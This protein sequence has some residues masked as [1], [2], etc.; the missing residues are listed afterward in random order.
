METDSSVA[1][2]ASAVERVLAEH[3]GGRWTVASVAQSWTRRSFE[4]SDGER[5][6]FVKLDVRAD[7]LRRLAE[8]GVAPPVLHDGEHGGL[9]L[10]VQEFIDGPPVERDWFPANLPTLAK[11]VT[12][13]HDD[14][15]LTTM[16]VPAAGV[17]YR[18]VVERTVEDL[19]RRSAATAC[20]A[21]S[22][23]VF[24][25]AAARVGAAASSLAEVP[26]VPTHGDPNRRNVVI[27]GERP[28]FVDGDEIAMADPLRDVG[29]L[30][31]WYLPRE[32]W[33]EFLHLLGIEESAATLDRLFWWVATEF[34]E[35]SLTTAAAGLET[36][37]VAFLRDFE[38]A[39]AQR[40]NPRA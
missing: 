4:G 34:L 19:M 21:I 38:A 9:W 24:R 40:P 15:D 36:D 35:V 39:L 28:Y 18:D 25:A 33:A 31:W 26:L 32:R 8:L 11:L 37:A 14:A 3:L 20:E 12:A 10:V 16:L 23:S 1:A 29:Q 5:R 30:A 13:Y 2:A 17:T 22:S 27:S 7:V 6:V